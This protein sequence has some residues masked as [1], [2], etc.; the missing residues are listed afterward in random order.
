MKRTAA[1]AC[2]V[3]IGL[4]GCEVCC[5][6]CCGSDC[7]V[8]VEPPAVPTGVSSIT[9]DGYVVVLWNPVYQ[10]DVAGY[11]VYRSNVADGPY[12]RIGDVDAEELTEFTDYQVVN[13]ITYYYA[14]DAYDYSGNESD[15]SYETVEDTPRPE[16]WDLKWYTAAFKPNQAAIAILPDLYRD[17]VLVHVDSPNAQY[18]LGSDGEC[19]RIYPL[20]DQHGILHLIQDFGYTYSIDDVDVA[21][22]EGW[23]AACDGVELIAGHTYVLRTSTG[24]YGKVRVVAA[25]PDFVVIDWAYQ[26]Q[27]GSIELGPRTPVGDLVRG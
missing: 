1:F 12:N 3:L 5:D 9:A 7:D 24:Y 19:L 27:R 22:T 10:A 2:V 14:V 8:D 16:G 15:L 18:W 21:P 6:S 17:L 20:R 4:A 13:G 25:T 23:S 26:V 11:G